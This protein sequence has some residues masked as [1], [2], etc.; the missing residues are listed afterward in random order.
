MTFKEFFKA[1]C[2]G[3]EPF[4]WQERLATQVLTGDWPPFIGLPTAAGKTALIDIAVFALAKRAP[5]AA[6]RIFFVVD[7][8][9]IVDEAAERAADIALRLREAD[10]ASQ[11]GGVARSLRELGDDPDPLHVAVLRGGIPRDDS[12]ASSPLQPL[13]VCT[14]VDQIGSS[15]LFR[16]YG[17]SEYSRPI[18]AALAAYDSL[19]ILDEAHTSQPFSET[20]NT[21]AGYRDWCSEVISLPIILVQMSA[22]PGAV[23]VFAETEADR[24][25]EVLHRRWSAP[26]RARLVL[27]DAGNPEE[28]PEAVIASVVDALVEQSRL[29]RDERRATVI[30]VICN[31][32]QTARRVHAVLAGDTG[33]DAILLTGR[34]RPFDRDRLWSNWRGR[35]GLGRQTGL[36]QPVFVVA[37]Q[38]IEVGANIDFDALVTEAAS[39]DALEQRF[40]RLNRAGRDCVSHA[41]IVAHKDQTKSKYDDAVYGSSLSATWGWL[42]KQLITE[43]RVIT[44]PAECKKKPRSKKV[45]ERFVQMAVLDLRAALLAT[46]NRSALIMP[47]RSA[48]VLMPAHMDLLCQ[49]SPEPALTPEPAL[50]LHGPASGP[51]DVQV[52]WRQDLDEHLQTAD[53]AEVVAVCPP[54]SAEAIAL[55]PWTVRQWLGRRTVRDIADVEGSQSDDPVK[56]NST[57][58]FLLWRGPD[59]S[60]IRENPSEIGPG[61]TV[62]IPASYGGCDEWGWNPDSSSEVNDIGD[63]VKC[64]LGNPV[65]RLHPKLT[66]AWNAPEL[67]ARLQGAASVREVVSVLRTHVSSEAADWVRNAATLLVSSRIKLV[68]SSDDAPTLAAVFGRSRFQQDSSGASYTREIGLEEHM[69]GCAAW[70]ARFARLAPERV[71]RTIVEAARVHDIGKADPRFQAWLRGGNPV[72]PGELIAKSDRS[73][74]NRAA[75]ERARKLSG[76]PKGVR[77][78][79]QSMAMLLSGQR[80]FPEIDFDLLLHLVAA[81]HGRCRPFAPIVDHSRDVNVRYQGW[82]AASDHR[83]ERVGSGVA[84]RFWRLTRKY[85]W[86]GLAFLET[87]VRLADCCE[88][89]AEEETS[90]TLSIKE[91]AHA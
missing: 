15:L 77:H 65:L 34:A 40:G 12:W 70:A 18:R 85:G 26:K 67:A 90:G 69:D 57:R 37:T 30:G 19:I 13:V 23:G 33:C 39:I 14:T 51:A 58:P 48:P 80:D 76:Y 11:L 36:Q 41:A 6:R 10:P 72:K 7:R 88:S 46:E 50:F 27:A 43:Q 5:R 24:T 87:L 20:A 1:L 60:V 79:V 25:H 71:R 63:A 83:M 82:A 66:S 64:R 73:G 49:T 2:D 29:M 32:V 53:W 81:H 55:P 61:M 17:A 62:V 16:S 42:E 31:R 75:I 9:V 59:E 45:T 8:R 4:P 44:I 86:Y 54:G 47:R 21:I 84:E 74:L 68:H 38:C 91:A 3:G 52:I 56:D 28:S 22:T 35:I 89:E 78:E